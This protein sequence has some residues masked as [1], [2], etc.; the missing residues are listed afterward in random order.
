MQAIILCGGLGTR[1][2][3]L[4]HDTPK[5]MLN[6]ANKPFVEYIIENLTRFG[7]ND[8]VLLVG[9]LG[10]YFLPLTK[11]GYFSRCKVKLYFDGDNLLGTGGSLKNASDILKEEFFLLNGDTIFDINFLDLAFRFQDQEIINIAF[12]SI[13]DVSRYGHV[14]LKDRKVISFSSD[15][16]VGG[17]IINGGVYYVRKDLVNYIP[18][19]A[20][21]LERDVFPTLAEKGLVGGGVYDG[22]FLDIGVPDDFAKAEGF[23]R[24]TLTRPAVFF[25]RDDVLNHDH[26]YVYK[27]EDLHWID[28]AIE[29]IK[30]FNDMGYYVFVVTNQAGIAKGYYFTSDLMLFH[31]HMND[32]LRKYGAH[33]D[34]F[35]FCPFHEEA[36]VE[37]YRKASYRRKPNPGMIEDLFNKWPIKKDASF[38]VGDKAT[39]IEAARRAGIRGYLFQGGNLF[40]FLESHNLLKKRV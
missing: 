12:R 28:G 22:S 31:S 23:L 3:S 21:S 32:S 40:D 37:V 26:G 30:Y 1:L 9:Y 15:T 13:D 16:K 7:I 5:P 14:T 29:S 35:E 11:I 38:L 6:I 8:I 34:E 18:N 17:G 10:Q 39:D 24:D 4:T 27:I 25:D 33:I 36:T 2:G 19:G 20:C